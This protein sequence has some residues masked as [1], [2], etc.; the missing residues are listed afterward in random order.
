VA[1]AIAVGAAWMLSAGV[2]GII[3]ATYAA[4]PKAAAILESVASE[5]SGGPLGASPV[6]LGAA[7]V[8]EGEGLAARG[9]TVLG[10]FP[11][12]V[13]LAD[14]LGARRF[15]IPTEIWNKMTPTEQWAANQ[16]FLDQ[17]IARGDEIILS[18]PVKSISEATGSY[19]RELRYL[20]DESFKLSGNG[21]RMTR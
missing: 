13:E 15:N 4:A 3:A 9:K 18:N 20:M 11:D 2:P 14:E 12:Y 7:A 16:K 6:P 21:T 19:R 10:K 5:Y 1:L 17:L 8:R